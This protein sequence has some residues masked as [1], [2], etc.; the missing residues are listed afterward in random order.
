MIKMEMENMDYLDEVIIGWF[1]DK[2]RY[3]SSVL[4]LKA[5]IFALMQNE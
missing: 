3:F 2:D 5:M 4:S 1:W